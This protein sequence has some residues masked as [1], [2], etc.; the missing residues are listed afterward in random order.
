MKLDIN[1]GKKV[2]K[3]DFEKKIGSSIKYENVV[4]MMVFQLFLKNGSKDF[5]ETWSEC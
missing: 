5:V 1:K 4:K 3:P 2:T